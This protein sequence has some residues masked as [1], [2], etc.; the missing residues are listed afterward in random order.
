MFDEH[1]EILLHHLLLNEPASPFKALRQLM[2]FNDENFV[3]YIFFYYF[4]YSNDTDTKL[5]EHA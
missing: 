2:W 1:I 4:D 5:T 3:F